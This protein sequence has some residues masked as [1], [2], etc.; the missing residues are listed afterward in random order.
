[1]K[2]ASSCVDYVSL[3][4][5]H[6]TPAF[7][8]NKISVQNRSDYCIQHIDSL[9][10]L[11]EHLDLHSDVL[12][13]LD[14]RRL[15][16][17]NRRVCN[18]DVFAESFSQWNRMEIVKWLKSLDLTQSYDDNLIDGVTGRHL[19]AL[20][21]SERLEKYGISEI[22]DQD[23]VYDAIPHCRITKTTT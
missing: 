1:M 21:N 20:K 7:N 23:I 15:Q 14:D 3:L 17:I 9:R 13:L 8:P 5:H 18:N 11:A 6:H 16:I 22:L 10:T 2:A 12:A 19:Q 4:A